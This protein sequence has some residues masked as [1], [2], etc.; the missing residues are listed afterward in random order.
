MAF[1]GINCA[2]GFSS[3]DV[4]SEGVSKQP[5]FGSMYA[6]ILLTIAGTT[7]TAS[8][9]ET[10]ARC[11]ASDEWQY[12]IIPRGSAYSPGLPSDIVP[13]GAPYDISLAYGE[14]IRFTP[15]A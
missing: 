15:I 8:A 10:I 4:S 12:Q 6:S 7:I 3:S 14:S 13:P 5:I 11:Y 1:T 9:E 2:F